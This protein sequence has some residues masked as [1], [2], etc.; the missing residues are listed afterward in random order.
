MSHHLLYHPTSPLRV[1][2]GGRVSDFSVVI[3]LTSVSGDAVFGEGSS[4]DPQYK[5]WRPLSKGL[6]LL[7]LR[8]TA[9][10]LRG[11][12]THRHP[13]TPSLR[14]TDSPVRTSN[15][16]GISTTRPMRGTSF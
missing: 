15:Q 9:V 13:V 12:P 11:L 7:G 2:A 5:T 4:I 3:S 14:R 10:N 1:A 8:L 6:R 16:Y